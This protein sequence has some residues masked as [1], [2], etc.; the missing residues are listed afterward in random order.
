[1]A[2]GVAVRD[3]YGGKV[4]LMQLSHWTLFKC[5]YNS[6][7]TRTAKQA[8]ASQLSCQWATTGTFH[9]L[10]LHHEYCTVF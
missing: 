4:L 5:L 2:F 3:H 1:M 10:Q 8:Q 6:W 9:W 7:Q